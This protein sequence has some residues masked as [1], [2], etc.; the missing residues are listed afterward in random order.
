[1]YKQT[2]FFIIFFLLS[3]I[4]WGTAWGATSQI[5]AGVTHMV[6]LKSDGTLW[7][8]G[9]NTNGQLG[10]GTTTN[11]LSP[12]QIGTD[13]N[14]VSIRAGNLYTVALESDGTLWAWGDNAGGALGDGTTTN[15][16]SP[17]Q[18][19]TD[20]NWVSISANGLH[21]VALKSDGTLW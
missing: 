18:I 12:V 2:G 14:W 20:T 19:G 7:T 17:V 1:M 13:T 4:A 6:V 8:W 15:S 21:T 5:A 16:L 3:V 11:S 10:D 9:G